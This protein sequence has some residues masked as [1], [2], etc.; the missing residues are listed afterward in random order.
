MSD[1]LC[2]NYQEKAEL[3][4]HGYMRENTNRIKSVEMPRD[5]VKLI[6]I[7]YGTI[8][9]WDMNNIHPSYQVTQEYKDNVDDNKSIRRNTI[10]D[11]I[12]YQSFGS[13]NIK[14]G[15][16]KIWRLQLLDI[17]AICTASTSLIGIIDSRQV[18]VNLNGDFCDKLNNGY[19]VS[20]FKGRKY[21]KTIQGF[22]YAESMQINDIII[23]E[24]DMTNEENCTLK[25]K[26][27]RD[28]FTKDYGFAFQK[29]NPNTQWRLAIGMYY[30]DCIK[31]IQ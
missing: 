21:Y 7:W 10:Y 27:Y 31:L 17:D 4:V 14:Y 11:G 16:I 25:Y 3:G 12:C 26:I 5:L 13:L 2:F 6:T 15:D 29:I 9:Y 23:M 18:S 22:K 8:D 19:G 1:N 28:G 24:L 20:F 30:R